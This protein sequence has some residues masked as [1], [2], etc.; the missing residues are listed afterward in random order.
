MTNFN[1]NK[2]R[3]HFNIHQL[4]DNKLKTKYTAKKMSLKWEKLKSIKKEFNEFFKNEE[5][6][7]YLY[8][9]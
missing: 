3:T 4:S 5:L 1:L 6:F 2:S 9:E 8:C 7:R